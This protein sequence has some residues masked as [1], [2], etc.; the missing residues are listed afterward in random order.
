MMRG[1][2]AAARRLTGALVAACAVAAAWAPA[3]GASTVSNEHDPL[4]TTSSAPV[5]YDNSAGAGGHVGL[6]FNGTALV[7]AD[8]SASP[9]TLGLDSL[10]VNDCVAPAAD[11]VMC[12]PGPT[13]IKLS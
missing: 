10:T 3:A 13:T 1:P 6:S 2:G 7:F 11:T 9:V 12:P 4:V 5:T 8:A